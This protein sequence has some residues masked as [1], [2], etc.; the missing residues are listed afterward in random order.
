LEAGVAVALA[1]AGRFAEA[2]PAG[3]AVAGAE[4]AVAIDD[5]PDENGS[6]AMGQGVTL[7][8]VL[9]VDGAPR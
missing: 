2:A 1:A 6:D 3:G 5:A 9:M 7:E 4:A 8:L